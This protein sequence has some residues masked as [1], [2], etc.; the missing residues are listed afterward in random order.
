MNKSKIAN[1][2]L[3]GVLALAVAGIG[4]GAYRQ[5]V[6]ADTIVPGYATLHL[7]LKVT[8]P[9][10]DKI[11][12]KAVAYPERGGKNYYFKER[13]FT[14]DTPGVNNIEWYIRKIPAGNYN[15]SITSSGGTLTPDNQ[16]AILANDSV[17]DR[18]VYQ[19]YIGEPQAISSP[20]ATPSE[21]VSPESEDIEDPLLQSPTATPTTTPTAT[22]DSSPTGNGLSVPPV[23][24][25]P[26]M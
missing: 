21:I 8:I 20:V 13:T 15:V 24:S 16:L 6:Q 3:A 10:A 2:V 19:L 12:M 9:T 4:F 1:S 26:V 11:T 14:F 17:S 18:A 22:T 5:K 23:P 25:L 7:G